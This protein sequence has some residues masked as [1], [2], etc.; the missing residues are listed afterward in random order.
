M[1]AKRCHGDW[2]NSDCLETSL[3]IAMATG[4]GW[5]WL[6]KWGG[7]VLRDEVSCVIQM[8]LFCTYLQCL[9]PNID[10]VGDA[11]LRKI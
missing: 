7:G 5:W 11:A 4:D 6:K 3:Y 10:R 8:I 2:N 1:K 9:C